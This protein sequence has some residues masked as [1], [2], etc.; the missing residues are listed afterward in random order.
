[1]LARFVCTSSAVLLVVACSIGPTIEPHPDDVE[2]TT[3]ACEEAT[4]FSLADLKDDMP[5]PP[6]RVAIEGTPRAM[7][8]CNQLACS[9]EC[10]E[11]RCFGHYELRNESGD[12]VVRLSGDGIECGG[13]DC[14]PYC[15]PFSRRPVGRYR[16]VGRLARTS[17]TTGWTLTV[18]SWCRIG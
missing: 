12:E 5:S 17:A 16:V 7:L 11:N 14:S 10:C 6:A 18:T 13:D 1:M 4:T 3:G 9:F 2:Q 15:R 8:A